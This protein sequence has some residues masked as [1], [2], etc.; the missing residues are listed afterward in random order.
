[1][2]WN[3]KAVLVTGAGGFIGSHLAE[4]LVELGAKVRAFVHYN[5]LNSRGWLDR[6]EHAEAMQ[7]VSG[8]ICDRDSVRQA[9]DKAEVVFHLGALIAIPYSYS[10]PESYLRTNIQGTMNVLQAAREC[11]PAA[12]VHTSTSEVYGTARY[13]P[14]DEAH[15]LQG[16]SPYSAS[17]IGADKMAESFHC[18]F[19]VPVTTVR[20]FN[21][22]GP[23]QSARAVIPTIITQALTSGRVKLGSLTPTRDLNFVENTVDGFLLAG[24]TAAAVGQTVNLG[25]GREIS[26]GDLAKLIGRLVGRELAIETD[27]ERMRPANSEVERLLACNR[28]AA[29]LLGWSPKV[30]LEDGLTRTIEWTAANLDKYRPASYVV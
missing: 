29:D 6:S 19:H 13:V 2:N 5:A 15:P 16:Q 9:M 7:I 18:S 12:V 28:K 4:R 1:M 20:P 21:T 30:T 3:G 22:F 27:G 24:S 11:G 25:T 8:D 14:I 23:R 10:A 17:K 26:I